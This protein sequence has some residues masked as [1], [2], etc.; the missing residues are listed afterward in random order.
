MFL[1]IKAEGQK[2]GQIDVACPGLDSPDTQMGHDL[3]ISP[4]LLLHPGET[5][6]VVKTPVKRLL[7]MATGYSLECVLLIPLEQV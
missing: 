6:E 5:L 2:N 7:T 3:F 1:M 4:A